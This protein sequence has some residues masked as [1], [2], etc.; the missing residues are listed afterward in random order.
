MCLFYVSD[1]TPVEEKKANKNVPASSERGPKPG[2][3]ADFGQHEP[4]CEAGRVRGPW[5]HRPAGNA[6]REGSERGTL[7]CKAATRCA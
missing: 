6:D 1:T 2:Q 5:S 4:L 3:G 7:K